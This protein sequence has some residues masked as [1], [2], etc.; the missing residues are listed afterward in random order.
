[1]RLEF[2]G[3]VDLRFVLQRYLQYPPL[4]RHMCRCQAQRVLHTWF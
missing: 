2:S 4:V 1:M 3:E